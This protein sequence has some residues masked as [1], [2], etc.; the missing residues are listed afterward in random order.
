[1]SDCHINLFVVEEHNAHIIGFYLHFRVC[2]HF[3]RFYEMVLVGAH[4]SDTLCL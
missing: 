4:S 3:T 1:M 2:A